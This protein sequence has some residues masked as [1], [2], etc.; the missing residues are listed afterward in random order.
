MKLNIIA[1]LL[2]TIIITLI[3]VSIGYT[4]NI[5]D[6]H[7]NNDIIPIVSSFI[8]L[9]A[10]FIIFKEKI[11]SWIIIKIFNEFVLRTRRHIGL[12]RIYSNFCDASN[13]IKSDFKMASDVSIFIQ[14]GRGVIGGQ[15]SLLFDEAKRRNGKEFKFRLLFSRME[16]QWLSQE[17]AEKRKSNHREWE[18]V[19]NFNIDNISVLESVGINIDARKHSEP[20]LW[21][22]FFFDNILYFIPYLYE[23]KNDKYAQVFK[24]ECTENGV[25]SFYS[26]FL[27]YYNDIWNKNSISEDIMSK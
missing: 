27:K 24:F 25:P 26:I 6:I 3:S 8:T 9:F 5:L 12:T 10:I 23:R 14:L 4:V 20:Y 17:R 18:S 15:N 11:Q 16:S 22:L 21:R 7:D 2:A 1:S 13:D 19:V